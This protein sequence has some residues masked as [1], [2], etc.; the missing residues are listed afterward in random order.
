MASLWEAIGA[1]LGQ[2]PLS[3][4]IPCRRSPVWEQFCHNFETFIASPGV[5][6][7]RGP[8]WLYQQLHSRSPP[9]RMTWGNLLGGLGQ[10]T[11]DAIRILLSARPPSNELSV[12]SWNI[13][14]I[15]DQ[16]SGTTQAKRALVNALLAKGYVVCLQETH[17]SGTDEAIWLHGLHIRKAYSSPAT[18]TARPNATD[19]TDD[20]HTTDPA[21]PGRK[22]GVVILLP[23]GYEFIPTEC[24]VLVPGFAVLAA[25]QTPRGDTLD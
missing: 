9:S 11:P 18:E 7:R 21:Q 16:A 15:V 10:A 1:A 17:W 20:D 4:P 14:W 2:P 23:V 22:G 8:S 19:A 5:L 12:I 25:I 13:R 6:E 24:R 3:R